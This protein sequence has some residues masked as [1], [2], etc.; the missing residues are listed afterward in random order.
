MWVNIPAFSPLWRT[1]LRH[2]LYLPEVQP[3]GK[4]RYSQYNLLS[5]VPCAGSLHSCST[6]VLLGPTSYN[7]Q[8]LASGF[9]SGGT[10]PRTVIL[11][12]KGIRTQTQVRLSSKPTHFSFILH[13]WVT[14]KAIPTHRLTFFFFKILLIYS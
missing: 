4:P 10:Q 1:A 3:W 13:I 8:V 6:L 12:R 7:L 5:G 9:T 2:Q 11:R 14:R